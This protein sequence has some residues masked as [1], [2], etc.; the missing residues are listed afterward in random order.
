MKRKFTQIFQQAFLLVALLSVSV[1]STN[2]Q[3]TLTDDD[4]VVT[5]GHLVS[6]D[7]TN[8]TSA[9]STDI[10]IPET[11]DGQTVTGIFTGQGGF[12]AGSS[13]PTNLV[14]LT[15]P[16]T[17]DSI[18]EKAFIFHH[19]LENVIFEGESQLLYIGYAT[20]AYC[21]GLTPAG[22]TLPANLVK[23]QNKA[24]VQS[25]GMTGLTFPVLP[26]Y[27]T[28]WSD[29]ATEYAGGDVIPNLGDVTYERTAAVQDP[30]TLTD[31]DVEVVN[32]RIVSM[33]YANYET[34]TEVIIPGTLDGQTVTGLFAGQGGFQNGTVSVLS[35]I[36][37]PASVDS[38]GE[39]AF[40]FCPLTDVVFEG[41]SQLEYIGFAAFAYI[42]T[43]APDV[44]PGLT[45]PASLVKIQNKAFVASSGLQGL[46]FPVV[47]GYISTWN[48]GTTDYAGGDVIANV[49]ADL[50][51]TR[52]AMVSATTYTVTFE[53][54]D[55]T[56]L[57]TETVVESGAATAPADPTRTGYTFTGW[58]VAF[59]NITAD[60]TV[61]AT[62]TIITYTITY[63]L[64][65]GTNDA[66]NPADYTIETAT[67]TLADAT[68]DG[69]TFKG[70]YWEA[71][72]ENAATEIT[73]GTAANIT[74][75]AK[76]TWIIVGP[77]TLTDDD[78]EVVN[79]RI[80]SMVYENYETATEIIIPGTLD[81]QTV[82]GLFALQGGFQNGVV[83]NLAKI[84]IPASVDSIGEKTFIFCPLTDVVFEGESQLKYIGFAAF[85]YLN[86]GTIA[87]DATPGLILPGSLEEIAPKAF[88]NSTDLTGLTFPVVPGFATTWNDG[89][90]DYA[91]GDEIPNFGD[92]TYIRTAIVAA[93]YTVTFEDHDGTVLKTEDVAEG[94]AATAPADPTRT[95]FDF[96]GWDVA[97]DN[98]T[99][100][101][102]VTAQYT[103]KSFTVIFADHDGTSLLE[104]LVE[105]G[106]GATA[107]ADPTRDGYSFTG[108]DVVFDNIT[109]D[110]TVTAQYAINSYTVTFVDHDGTSLKEESVEHGSA[111]TA[112]A[113]PTR[114]DH[115]FTGW[116]VA[117]DN[118]T[119]DLTVTAQYQSTVGVT[120][121]FTKSFRV[122]PNPANDVINIEFDRSQYV[123]VFIYNSIGHVVMSSDLSAQTMDVSALSAGVY[124]V[125]VEN[126]VQKVVIH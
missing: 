10:V 43:L 71:T 45:L 62:Y 116:D 83:S 29:G 69:Y 124:F 84:T 78:V 79:G 8:L 40:I 91:G 70:W 41:E 42:T 27:T 36:T 120:D 90:T 92:V 17:V 61:A 109:A 65:G 52:T 105:H 121:E 126:M 55:G 46:T 2:A 44:T 50:T 93:P 47:P 35:K 49:V 73:L 5:N 118:I 94:G 7:L 112:P 54:H 96:T 16:A 20:F 25:P 18:G 32:G 97:F 125:K 12:G 108:W 58:D 122:Y 80:V 23:L 57:K 98:I 48:D 67:I 110:L 113:D 100:D 101:L 87:P 9:D 75:Y 99:A 26:G 38:I 119:A 28:T 63:E 107:P 53:D 31:D 24:F 11:L 66:A 21:N 72:F 3:Y 4:A 89:T 74:L 123:Q 39:K 14:T 77:Y 111:A 106:S 81:G 95:G 37:I 103:I 19:T 117:F 86:K 1:L 13:E 15:I 102:T 59:D 22:L 88:V 115:I 82:T 60:L 30:Y 68:K 64:D 76:F 104:A 33:V 114:D 85:A 56:V 51:Y 34:K 6:V